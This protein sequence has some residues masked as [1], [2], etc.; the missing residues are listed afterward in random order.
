[1]TS[2]GA[3]RNGAGGKHRTDADVDVDVVDLARRYD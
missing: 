2:N 3:V 1:M